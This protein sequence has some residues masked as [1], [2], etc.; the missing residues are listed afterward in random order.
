MDGRKTILLLMNG[1][2]MEAPKSFNVY[3][4]SLM[5]SLAKLSKHYPFGSMYASGLEGGLNKGQLSSFRVGYLMFSTLGKPSK[6]SA[7]IAERIEQNVFDNNPVIVAS[8]NYALQ[9]QSRLHVLFSIGERTE[10]AQFEQLRRYGQL[11]VQSGIREICLHLFLGENSVQGMKVSAMWLKNLRSYVLNSLPQMKV[12][13]IA[14][15]KYLTDAP[16][17]VKLAYYRM[18]V[19]GVGEVWSNYEETLEK[20]YKNKEDDDSMGGF[21]TVR[22]N[23]IRS[24]DSVMNFNYDNNVGA[25]YLDIVQNPHEFFPVGKVPLNVSVNALFEVAENVNI[26]YAFES[27]L[28]KHYFLENLSARQ[29]VLIIADRDR[30][31]YISKCLNGFRSEF[32]SNINVWPIEDKA[33]RFELMAEYLAAYINQNTYDLIVADCELLSTQSDQK[34]ISQLKQNMAAID[35]ILNVAYTR[36]MEKG[37]TL[38][39][40]SLYGIKTQLLLTTTYEMVDFSQKVPLLIAGSDISRNNTFIQKEGNF[41]QVAT[42]VQKNLGITNE[43]SPLTTEKPK[44]TGKKIFVIGMIGFFILAVLLVISYLYSQGII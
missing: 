11:A 25:E 30:V 44:S 31:Q 8:I 21:L 23:V 34:T 35:S 36:G 32:N 29:R 33:K 18:I 6:K 42:L 16:K 3:T 17:D 22:E 15:R 39:A 28:P 14:G 13:S 9:Y 1:F 27:E 19:S 24:N 38:Y 26:P 2:G 41:T 12:V 10:P 20:K 4:E 7:L 5:P 43:A 40:T 37:Y